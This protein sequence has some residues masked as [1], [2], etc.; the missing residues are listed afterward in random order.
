[1]R[2]RG[3]RPPIRGEASVDASAETLGELDVSSSRPLSE[4]L[5]DLAL[6]IVSTLSFFAGYRF[7]IRRAPWFVEEL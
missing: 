6:V 7:F 4:P 3:P 2:R 1:M 5:F